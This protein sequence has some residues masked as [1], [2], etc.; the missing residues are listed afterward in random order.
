[1][2]M[3]YPIRI[4]PIRGRYIV[5][6]ALLLL[7]GGIAVTAPPAPACSAMNTDVQIDGV[8]FLSNVLPTRAVVVRNGS[9]DLY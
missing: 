1:M 4:Y 5:F 6:S 9:G 8:L 2:I 7:F 3:M